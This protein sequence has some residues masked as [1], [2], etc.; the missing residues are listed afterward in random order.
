MNAKN[1]YGETPVDWAFGVED[2]YQPLREN[3]GKPGN[4][5]NIILSRSIFQPYKDQLDQYEKFENE[6]AV[7]IRE[8]AADGHDIN[9]AVSDINR[10]W[11]YWKSTV[12]ED[13]D[14][15]SDDAEEEFGTDPLDPDDTPT[16]KEMA[17][18]YEYEVNLRT[19]PLLIALREMRSAKIISLL[20]E[21][22]A[23]VNV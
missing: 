13:G 20:I 23:D 1:K 18:Y 7:L 14:G 16:S 21:L 10:G 22:G 5:Y 9:A 11:D 19:T 2:L 3:G 4:N 15:A 12:D 6:M 17:E 8:I